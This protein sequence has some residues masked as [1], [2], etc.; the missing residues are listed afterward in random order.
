MLFFY[1]VNIVQLF[2][3]IQ[4]HKTA[5]IEG[6]DTEISLLLFDKGMENN[7]Y[8]P[9]LTCSDLPIAVV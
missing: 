5:L 2:Q 6:L 8:T 9:N 7:S 1:S 4:L 3:C